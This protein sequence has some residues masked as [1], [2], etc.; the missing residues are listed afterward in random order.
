MPLFYFHLFNDQD[1]MDREGTDLPDAGAAGAYA[2]QLAK[3]EA[4]EAV[5]SNGRIVL[6]HRIDVEDKDHRAVTT[7]WFRDVVHVEQ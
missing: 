3:F 2:S 1:V 7:V 6:S 5:K 4:G